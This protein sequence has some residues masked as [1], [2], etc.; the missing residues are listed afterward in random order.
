MDII[1]L[2]DDEIGVLFDNDSKRIFTV[3]PKFAE[4]Y[5]QGKIELPKELKENLEDIESTDRK[6]P[7]RLQLIMTTKCNLNCRYCYADGGNYGEEKAVISKQ[8]LDKVIEIVRKGNIGNILLFGGEPLIA[9]REIDYV[10][11]ALNDIEGLCYTMVTNL[12]YLNDDIIRIIKKYGI[13]ITVSLDGPKK[14]ND[15][16]RYFIDGKGTY[17]VILEN[18]KKLTKENIKIAKFECTYGVE[19]IENNISKEDIKKFF[20][21]MF[22]NVALEI[23]NER[24]KY[25]RIEDN[26]ADENEY[27]YSWFK[28]RKSNIC[29]AGEV[30]RAICP[31]GDIYPCQVFIGNP[32]YK[33]GNLLERERSIESELKNLK[34]RVD[35]EKC[36]SRMVCSICYWDLLYSSDYELEERC[37]YIKTTNRKMFL[38][39]V[40]ERQQSI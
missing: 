6:R 10:L 39:F 1:S 30:T 19:H 21:D 33:I 27:L 14:I 38:K 26:E 5:S 18:L 15:A 29:Q 31:N 7:G 37:N 25:I 34:M 35:C 22:P 17:D 32:K 3:T 24:N 2:W 4:D 40:K 13:I 12:T 16:N 9:Y 8:V 11:D 28:K 23:C 20:S 36:D